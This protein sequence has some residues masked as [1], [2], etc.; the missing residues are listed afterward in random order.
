MRRRSFLTGALAGSA[1][2][3]PPG[4]VLARTPASYYPNVMLRTHQNKKVRFYDDLLKDKIVVMNFMFTGCGDICPGMTENL[5][6]VQNILGY[7]VGRS[8]FMYSF[9]LQPELDSPEILKTYAEAFGA[10]PGWLFLTGASADIELLRRKL[11]FA[12]IDPVLDADIAQHIG[13]VRFGNDRL[14]RWA[15]CPALAEPQEIAREIL[16][17]EPRG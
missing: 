13:V 15:A 9:T 16:W 11:G 14:D 7:R 17:M 3:A 6:E 4:P 8:I 1:F 12:D 10:G 2:L 5:A